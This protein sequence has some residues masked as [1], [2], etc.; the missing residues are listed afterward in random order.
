ML[1][2]I[3]L[4][5]SWNVRFRL[6]KLHKQ[7][8]QGKWSMTVHTNIAVA[9]HLHILQRIIM[10]NFELTWFLNTLDLPINI[11]F[12]HCS[13]WILNFIDSSTNSI[14][15]R[16]CTRWRW[17]LCI[18]AWHSFLLSTCGR[19]LS[20]I[21]WLV[22]SCLNRLWW[23]RLVCWIAIFPKINEKLGMKCRK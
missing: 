22:F 4:Q 2:L 3:F 5:I 1:S 11:F 20:R 8:V 14:L 15:S 17:G 13:Y 12:T 18:Q 23:L 19:L 7:G 16:S 9:L 21:Y 10:K 6:K